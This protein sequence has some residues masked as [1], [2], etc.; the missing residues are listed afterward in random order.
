MIGCDRY[1]LRWRERYR[2][3]YEMFSQFFDHDEDDVRSDE[4]KEPATAHA[5][6]TAVLV[7]TNKDGT[8]SFR[9]IRMYIHWPRCYSHRMQRIVGDRFEGWY[10]PPLVFPAPATSPPP[11]AASTAGE[12]EGGDAGEAGTRVGIAAATESSPPLI[13]K[14]WRCFFREKRSAAGLAAAEGA[15]VEEA[16]VGEKRKRA[17]ATS[18]SEW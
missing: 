15:A 18:S 13:T 9:T 5:A 2:V 8:D 14:Q 6:S 1:F 3:T 17:N 10:I 7:P 12:E 16:G 11:N 4:D